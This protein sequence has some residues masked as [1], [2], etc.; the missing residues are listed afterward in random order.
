MDDLLLQKIAGEFGTPLYVYDGDR[1][2]SQYRRLKGMLPKEFNV[3][4][5][6]KSNPTLGIAGLFRGL[7]SG[8]EVASAGELYL[9]LQAGFDPRDIIFTSPGKT[10]EEL[11]YA[12]EH[13]IYSINIESIAEAELINQIGSLRSRQINVAI[14]IN[15][16]FN[17]SG[18]GI[19]MAGVP[20]QFGIDQSQLAE[21]F[22]SLK[23]LSFVK[24]IGIHV[25]TGTQMLSTQN[26]LANME[27]IIKLALE[28]A[29][30]Y[31]FKLEFLD[32]GGG[33][34]VPYFPGEAPFDETGLRQGMAAVWDT[35]RNQLPGGVN[36]AVESG[37]YLT[38]E[39]GVF[40]TQ[41]LYTKECK[42]LKYAVC[43]GGSN[44]HANSAF[45]GRHIRNNFPMH[46]LGKHEL[47]TELTV[48]GPLCTPTDVIGQ[49]VMLPAVTPGDIISI[50]KSGAYG[51][52]NSPLFFLSHPLPA[53]VVHYQNKTVIIRERGKL[54]D[55][56]KGQSFI[57][58]MTP[59]A[60]S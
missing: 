48:V 58:E 18:A 38:A 25:Y 60:N 44:Q 26:I 22:Q 9:A 59:L 32:L 50:D 12:V 14:R 1:I 49:K 39:S 41:I 57:P 21:A 42:G 24:I 35:Y 46:V 6:L 13:Q 54:E 2:E 52:S 11:E 20:T 40:L 28:L 36:M 31:Q 51:L 7:G 34:G 33:F 17:L 55:F 30:Q 53:E 19:K 27:A 3:Y 23:S 47:P 8:I 5:S 37:R 29:E 16:D 15:P 56:V 4:Y 45:L 10:R 43:D